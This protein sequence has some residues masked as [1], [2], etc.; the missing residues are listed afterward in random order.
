MVAREFARDLKVLVAAQPTRGIDV[1][2]IEYIHKRI[3]AFRDEGHAVLVV[4]SELDEVL[5]LGDR[6]AVMYRG[7][8]SGPYDA[9]VDRD[10]IGLLMAGVD[11]TAPSASPGRPGHDRD[12]HAP[13]RPRRH[14]DGVV[15]RFVHEIV[16]GQTLL[17]T[18]LSVLTA[19][20]FGALLIILS[21]DATR[22]P[23][24]YVFA[25]PG[26]FFSAVGTSVGDAYASL[27]TGSLGGPRA[28]SETLV[29]A[30]PLILTALAFALPFRALLINIG[31]EGQFIAGA[32]TGSLVGFGIHGLPLLVHLPLVLLAGALG[33]AVYGW[34]P[35]ILKARTGAHEVIV[36]I[37]L[38][39]IGLLLLG[40]MLTT[41]VVQNP[42]RNDPISKAL[43]SSAQLP[44]LRLPPPCRPLRRAGGGRGLLVADRAQHLRLRGQGGRLQPP[45]RPVRRDAPDHHVLVDPADRWRHGRPGRHRDHRR[46]RTA[47]A[48][49]R[50]LRRARA[51]TA[52]PW[53]CSGRSRPAGIVL[54]A[55]L[56]GALE[57]GGLRM[58]AD[59]QTSLDLVTVV[60]AMV[61]IFIAAPALIRSIYRVRAVR[62]EG[63]EASTGWSA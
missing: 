53:R 50:L 15:A 56:F 55:V 41:D 39:N 46:A 27:F 16:H 4:S 29:A 52:S 44:V 32:M 31:G 3:V 36:T 19:L 11:P 60:Q 61:V 59:T 54:A 17:V 6:V 22:E 63:L 57:A 38:N 20:A 2:S 25:R 7:R 40:W 48:H 18:A 28:W 51:S 24:T 9:P 10:Q 5:A 33:G 42:G 62:S 45:R 49:R 37:M 1:G 34:I 26:D 14:D 30:T 35:G 21:E 47:P 23:L 43:A 58:Q 12:P 13:A 8:L